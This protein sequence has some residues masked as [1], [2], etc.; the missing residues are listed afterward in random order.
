M[1]LD[2]MAPRSAPI[3]RR[4]PYEDHAT[5]APLLD[6]IRAALPA[7]R[8][9]RSRLEQSGGDHLLLIVNDD[10]VFRFPRTGVRDLRLEV[11]V[12]RQ[13]RH[14]THIA[15]P[16]YDHV[17]PDGRFGGYR[18]IGGGPLTDTLFARLD[19]GARTDVLDTAARFLIDLH[20]LL[21][22]D[23][24]WSGDWPR[25]WTAAQFADRG[26][27]LR[28][29]LIARFVPRLAAPIEAFYRL[30]RLD[31]T[32]R[33]VIVHGDLV[34]EH[35]LVDPNGRR[36]TGIIDFGDVALG[37]PAQDLMGFWSYGAE[38]ASRVVG[39]YDT[40]HVDP[41]LLRRSR[42]H[43]TRHRID[44]LFEHLEAG[45]RAEVSGD[46]AAVEALLDS[47]FRR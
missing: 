20:G 35:M 6:L 44:Q 11:E 40:G 17:E 34:G 22:T 46:I 12:L 30:H 21:Q 37:D 4:L 47:S 27:T 19:D 41:D 5:A 39:Q 31:R 42:N 9:C 2:D 15:V 28:L 18:Y 16:E 26:M 38:A 32:D 33:P 43:F 23:I 13:L 7:L 24:A 25:T 10:Q 1:L 36:L 29:P 3:G 45:G 14:R 8:I